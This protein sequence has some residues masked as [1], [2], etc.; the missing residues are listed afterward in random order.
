M[1]AVPVKWYIG[2][3]TKPRTHKTKPKTKISNK[4]WQ[5]LV[6]NQQNQQPYK[7]PPKQHFATM[8]HVNR[9]RILPRIDDWCLRIWCLSS[10]P[11]TGIQTS[12]QSSQEFHPVAFVTQGFVIDPPR[13]TKRRLY[14]PYSVSSC[15]ILIEAHA[16]PLNNNTSKCTTTHKTSYQR[17]TQWCTLCTITCR[18]TSHPIHTYRST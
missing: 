14:S 16:A 2:S 7:K 18:C 11:V 17:T 1:I 8:G 15:L 6:T 3:A 10:H 4:H 5:Q 9:S 12:Q 13:V